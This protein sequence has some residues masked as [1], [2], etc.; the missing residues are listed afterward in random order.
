MMIYHILS[1]ILLYII[2]IFFILKIY[3][4]IAIYLPY[5]TIY[6]EDFF[7]AH[8]LRLKRSVNGNSGGHSYRP[9][10][11]DRSWGTVGLCHGMGWWFLLR[12]VGW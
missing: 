10:G 2:M 9:R 11:P 4:D 1:S 6:Y 7:M 3:Y 12:L 8:F 5:L